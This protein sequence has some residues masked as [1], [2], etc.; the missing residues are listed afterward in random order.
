MD[1]LSRKAVH[2]LS[3]FAAAFAI[4]LLLSAGSFRYWNGWAFL[5]N[6]MGCSALITWWFLAHDPA[7]ISRRMT[8]GPTAE[9]EIPQKRVQAVT[10]ALFVAYPLIGGL[11]NRYG[12]SAMGCGWI[13]LGH[14]LIVAGFL[15]MFAV[16][17]ANSF[18]ASTVEIMESQ[19]VVDSGP[20]AIVR[21]P[22]YAAAILLFLGMPLALGSWWALLLFV[23]MTA[24][25]I[26]R[27]RHEEDFLAERLPGY[28][29]Y[30]VRVPF[31]LFPSVY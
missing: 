26:V 13:A 28:R 4:L 19:R 5:A 16:F 1:D 31:R 10:S 21:H 23:P 8:V 7:L 9:K 22:M 14:A 6:F 27:L 20:Y 30:M 11:D 12:S 17:R 25:L 18:A 24:A 15:G 29:A 3:V 2:N